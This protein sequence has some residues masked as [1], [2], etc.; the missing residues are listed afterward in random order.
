VVIYSVRID[1]EPAAG[2]GEQVV[3]RAGRLHD[4]LRAQESGAVQQA[5]SLF[6]A[7]PGPHHGLAQVTVTVQAADQG[8]AATAA[9]KALR[10]AAGDDRRAWEITRARITVGPARAGR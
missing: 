9:L 1:L 4:R 8:K 2:P 7:R 10:A 6:R 5:R 3:S